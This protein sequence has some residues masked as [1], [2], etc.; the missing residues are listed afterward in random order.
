MTPGGE[1]AARDLRREGRRRARHL[2]QGAAGRAGHGR[3]G[4]RLQP[5]RRR[6]GR[7][8]DRDRAGR[9]RAA[10]QGPRR[11]EGDPRAQRLQPPARGAR[12]AGGRPRRPQGRQGRRPDRRRDCSDGAAAAQW[13]EIGVDDADRMAE[14][15]AL[16]APARRRL[17][18]AL[19][20]PVREQGREAAAR[21]R[22][23][24]RRAQDGQGVRRGEAQ[25]A[26]GRQ[27]GRPPR[28]QGRDL[29]DRPRSRTC[30]TS[31]TARRSTSCSIR[32]ACRRG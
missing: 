27:D 8:R 1:A 28:Q 21:R 7:A 2:A 30:R 12:R 9:D 17:R 29:Q 3:R 6:E 15:Q 18:S 32:W 5:P 4:A 19:E 31:R 24:A 10:G 20:R 13:W 25:A 16:Q 11:R 23:A 26:A 14:I 22:A